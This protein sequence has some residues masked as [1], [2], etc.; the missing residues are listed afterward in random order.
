MCSP[1]SAQVGIRTEDPRGMLHVDAKGDTR[2]SASD[3]V[4]ISDD[5]VVTPA[6]RIGVG[7]LTP[8]T[9]LD[10]VGSIRIQDGNEGG[11]KV[12]ASDANG[13]A[14]WT[15]IA[16]S[17][18]AALTGGHLSGINTGSDWEKVWPP[19]SY[20]GAESY[21]LVA[22]SG[23]DSETGIITVPYTGTYRISITGKAFTNLPISF[24]YFLAYMRVYVND[25]NLES[26]H[27]HS[28]LAF[29]WVDFGFT[30]FFVLNAGDKLR[31]EPFRNT[32]LNYYSANQYSDTILQLE[33]IK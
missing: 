6:G 13:R 4:N 1:L 20:T 2:I 26:P 9:R 30:L 18:Y 14:T 17:W 29:G 22:G 10:V 5:V 12:L 27:L 16:G 8:R 3:T 7:T 15:N 28:L 19:F 33:F 31:I 23:A 11:G 32:T 21:P 24:S 25:Y